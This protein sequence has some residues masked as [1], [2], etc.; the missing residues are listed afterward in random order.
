MEQMRLGGLP[1]KFAFGKVKSG[2]Y[3]R[4][5]IGRKSEDELCKCLRIGILGT[6][7]LSRK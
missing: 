5:I 2:K 1:R 3:L 4:E 6:I 7:K